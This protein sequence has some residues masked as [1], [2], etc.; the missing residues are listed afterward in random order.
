MLQQCWRC[1]AGMPPSFQYC[2]RCGI[3]LKELSMTKKNIKRT[4]KKEATLRIEQR[5]PLSPTPTDLPP[6][7]ENQMIKLVNREGNSLNPSFE[8]ELI[9]NIQLLEL[10]MASVIDSVFELNEKSNS[11][12]RKSFHTFHPDS[13]ILPTIAIQDGKGRNNVSKPNKLK[14]INDSRLSVHTAEGDYLSHIAPISIYYNQYVEREKLLKGLHAMAI[15]DDVANADNANNPPETKPLPPSEQSITSEESENASAWLWGSLGS[16]DENGSVITYTDDI[17]FVTNINGELNSGGQ[18]DESNC[19]FWGDI[20]HNGLNSANKEFDDKDIEEEIKTIEKEDLSQQFFNLFGYH[21]TSA[22]L[23]DV[24][25]MDSDGVPTSTAENYAKEKK[26][27]LA[28][29]ASIQ[30]REIEKASTH[31]EEES[32]QL[33][34][35]QKVEGNIRGAELQKIKEL[36]N[37]SMKAITKEIDRISID[38]RIDLQKQ[39][40]YFIRDLRNTLLITEKVIKSAAQ[41]EADVQVRYE[42]FKVHSSQRRSS[43]AMEVATAMSTA[44]QVESTYREK[45]D[46]AAQAFKERETGT[47]KRPQL[48]TQRHI[49]SSKQMDAIKEKAETEMKRHGLIIQNLQSAES[50]LLLQIRNEEFAIVETMKVLFARHSR[51]FNK[52][53]FA[54][55][56]AEGVL[57]NASSR[58]IQQFMRE[59]Y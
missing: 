24:F 25:Q 56:R 20:G 48:S 16:V 58:R 37:R 53:L 10:E 36:Y 33:S 46:L 15:D 21:P 54:F 50:Q 2:S 52:L 41:I 51:T 39:Q 43:M 44:A 14:K 1:K 40:K 17:S 57:K 49:V 28:K 3:I 59:N 12:E 29:E 18:V 55:K 27:R 9:G 42:D 7:M 38:L 32:Q 31:G 45:Y 11:H 13:I 4:Q 34:Q 35:I 8:K 19:M 6:D 26:M 30:R 47:G 5:R 22:D 23:P